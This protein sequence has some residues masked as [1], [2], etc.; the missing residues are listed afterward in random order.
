MTEAQTGVGSNYCRSD[1]EILSERRLDILKQCDPDALKSFTDA[2]IVVADKVLR[3]KLNTKMVSA[4]A[5][6]T[7]QDVHVYHSHDRYSTG[8]Y[9]I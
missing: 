6:F 1:F 4:F 3:D 7:C 5:S 8:R 2:P 9:S